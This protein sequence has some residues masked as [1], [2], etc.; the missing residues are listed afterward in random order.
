MLHPFKINREEWIHIQQNYHSL[1]LP[2]DKVVIHILFV[3][4]T[5]D[6]SHVEDDGNG[7]EV[8][9]Q[10]QNWLDTNVKGAYCI[11][12]DKIWFELEAD[13]VAFKLVWS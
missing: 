3:I 1:P 10:L 4:D 11:G 12:P 7:I 2:P 13:A 6:D 9:E 5:G 8:D